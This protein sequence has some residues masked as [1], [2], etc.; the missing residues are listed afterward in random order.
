MR[1]VKLKDIE[2]ALEDNGWYIARTSGGHKVYKH[3]TKPGIVTITSSKKGDITSWL[4]R[5]IEK[6][7]GLK[8]K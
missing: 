2:K 5:E 1:N 4:L 6:Q 3:P 7:S 8:F